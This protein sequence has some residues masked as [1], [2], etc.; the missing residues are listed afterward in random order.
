VGTVNRLSCTTGIPAVAMYGVI[1]LLPLLLVIC[2][3]RWCCRS[4]PKSNDARG[5]YRTIAATYG[6][7]S[8]GDNAFSED[9]SDDD[10]GEEDHFDNEYDDS[11]ATTTSSGGTKRVLEMGNL[12]R[13]Y[14]RQDRPSLRETN[15]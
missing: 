10:D 1:V 9:Y 3:Y 2:G 7:A 11:W 8:F 13:Q 4:G 14:G 15:G 6:D 12:G 5:E